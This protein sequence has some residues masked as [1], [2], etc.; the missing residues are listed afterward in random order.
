MSTNHCPY[1]NASNLKR[2]LF[3]TILPIFF[4]SLSLAVQLYD[5]VELYNF[6]KN[7]IKGVEAI[8][9]L[10]NSLTDL[11]KIRGY[12]QITKWEQ[13]PE[14]K[15]NL[16]LLKQSF[17]NR[18]ERSDW[19]VATRNL[20]LADETNRM[21]TRARTL[22]TI[23]PNGSPARRLFS[24][25]S[26]CITDI[27]QLIQLT[28]DHAKLILDPNI[29]TYYLIDI[30]DKQIPYLAE[31]IG[32][33]R[34]I[35]SGLLAKKRTDHLER[36]TL[37]DYQ[38]AIQARIESIRNAQDVITQ[39]TPQLKDSLHLL[40]DNLYQHLAPLIA[41]CSLI[42]DN[43]EWPNMPPERFFHLATRAIGLLLEP[44]HTGILLL[45][46]RLKKR[47]ADHLRK[48]AMM[49]FGTGIGILLMLYFNRSFYLYDQKNHQNME[50][51]SVTDQLT[52]LYNRRHLYSVFPKESRRSVR[53]NDALFLILLDVDHFKRYNDTYGHPKG[54]KV[55]EQIANA[56]TATMRRAGDYC[57]RIGGEE[58]CILFNANNTA[59][60]RERTEDVRQ[61][62][63]DLQIVH[64]GNDPHGVITVSLGLTAI[65]AD[66]DCVLEH[67]M[68]KVDQALYR[69]KERGRNTFVYIS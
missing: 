48:G 42:T 47:Q 17:L 12:T 2:Y 60:A 51:L 52:G 7:E 54:D 35:G 45:K 23:Q 6:T 57:F 21:L 68:T 19:T 9:V 27:L 26:Q 67:V 30:L 8:N 46:E 29:E 64:T 11:Q 28:A 44:Y 5:Q 63:V 40:P 22:F 16:F 49:F 3:A 59:M 58:F 10:F 32:R 15:K 61:A 24:Q 20:H 53:H 62:I 39:T 55:L 37:H 31:A 69:A 1:N 4:L 33:V 34:G 66:A 41:V 65:P 18:F 25:F 14:I 13:R 36:E 56:M 50:K 38:V 43:K